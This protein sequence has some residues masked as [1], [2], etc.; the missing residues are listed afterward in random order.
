MGKSRKS[1]IPPYTRPKPCTRENGRIQ[2][3]EEY[4]RAK[5]LRRKD[6]K[7]QKRIS[8]RLIIQGNRKADSMAGQARAEAPK[9]TPI[10]N[11]ADSFFLMTKDLSRTN[12]QTD[13]KKTKEK[14][15]IPDE[16][17]DIEASNAIF[18]TKH[19]KLKDFVTKT[20][21]KTI[22]CRKNINRRVTESNFPNT[23]PKNKKS[24][25]YIK[26]KYHN[27]TC[28]H[29]QQEAEDRAHIFSCKAY[30]EHEGIM[31]MNKRFN[32]RF[33]DLS[34]FNIIEFPT[35]FPSPN[36]QIANS[37]YDET[38]EMYGLLNQIQNYNKDNRNTQLWTPPQIR[39]I[40]KELQKTYPENFIENG[41]TI[42][43]KKIIQDIT[44]DIYS[45]LKACT[46]KKWKNFTK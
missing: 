45:S 33:Q 13:K 22:C 42:P 35:W 2:E 15:N 46:M 31:E 27:T 37:S 43:I 9:N 36:P 19:T 5:K 39:T 26:A 38:S 41:N 6:R 20:R 29:C 44:E 21:S 28:P 4:H 30:E 32:K 1:Q 18:Q 8:R 40:C 16:D 7:S 12:R 17:K 24:P 10:P 23:I 34:N 25:Q 3:K 11:G 14:N